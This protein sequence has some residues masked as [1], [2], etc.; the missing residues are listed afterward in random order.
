LNSSRGT[1][2]QW[3]WNFGDGTTKTYTAYKD[4]ILHVYDST[5]IYHVTLNIKAT[6]NNMPITGTY[7][8]IIN[9]YR[10]PIADFGYNNSCASLE[11]KFTDSTRT[12]DA[13]LS[14]WQWTFNDPYNIN[15]SSGL[16]NPTYLYD[17]AGTYSVQLIVTDNNNCRDTVT[18]P[19][20]MHSS[21]VAAFTVTQ[22]Y[23][24]VTGQVLLNNLSTGATQYF[25]DFGDGHSSTE[26]SPVY[27]Y[28]SVG[29]FKILLTATNDY[30][31]S[32]TA[33]NYI[34]LTSG[35]YVPNSFA[36]N[37]EHAGVKVFKPKGINL[38]KY[39][40][41]VFNMW[42]DLLWESTKLNAKGEPTEGWNG[43]YKGQPMPEGDYI[44][45]IEAKFLDGSTWK[46]SDNGD[47]NK[48]PY[49]TVFL[50]R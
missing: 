40:I 35:L 42:G 25:W 23:N 27:Q 6:V 32:D 5:G 21:P 49:G 16:Q 48:K 4:S 26:T 47:G 9:I 20:T 17:S 29:I 8:S 22:N 28:E 44:W 38:K 31:C 46:G 36:P 2:D 15:D 14:K 30:M 50:I 3:N 10:P 19:V 39:D 18:K 24:N 33:S 41:Q 1:I 11:T 13:A 12:F 37:S 34:D 43:T 7:D 45:R